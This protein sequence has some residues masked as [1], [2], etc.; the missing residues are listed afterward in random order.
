MVAP[1]E[2]QKTDIIRRFQRLTMEHDN[3]SVTD[4]FDRL[5]NHYKTAKALDGITGSELLGSR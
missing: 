3:E 5:E 4:Y 1:T 2:S